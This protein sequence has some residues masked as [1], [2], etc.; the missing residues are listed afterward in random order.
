MAKSPPITE[1]QIP[2]LM[3]MWTLGPWHFTEWRDFDGDEPTT[4]YRFGPRDHRPTY[5]DDRY[6]SLGEAMLVAVAERYEG[7]PESTWTAFMCARL[8]GMHHYDG[9]E[10]VHRDPP[11]PYRYA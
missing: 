3:E 7:A 11:I 9:G 1:D 4:W 6:K 10:W 8:I 2:D 5:H